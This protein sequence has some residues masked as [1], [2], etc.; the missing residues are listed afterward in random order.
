MF[1]LLFF[2]GNDVNVRDDN[3]YICFYVV[4]CSG[5][6]IYKCCSVELL[7]IVIGFLMGCILKR[8]LF[9]NVEV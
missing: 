3:D 7:N 8:K 4:V 2:L 1:N 6:V 9:Y 5:L